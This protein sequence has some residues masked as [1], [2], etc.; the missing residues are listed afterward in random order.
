M[1]RTAVVTTEV[2]TFSELGPKARQKAI[3]NRTEEAGQYWEAG[4]LVK[5]WVEKLE[6]MG[7]EDVEINYSG[8][9]SQGDGASFTSSKF[10]LCH[11]LKQ[12]QLISKV[13]N[14]F[15]KFKEYDYFSAHH[16][17]VRSI[18]NNYSHYNTVRVEIEEYAAEHPQQELARE[19]LTEAV[20]DLCK[21]IYK[22]LETSYDHDTSEA[23]A[24]A[25]LEDNEE[26]NEFTEEGS[27]Y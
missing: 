24:I 3:D 22:E 17:T 10:D 7:F 13:P 15:R 18:C 19:L 4:W 23:Q 21:Q 11:M 16:C 1:S 25:Y 8:F 12:F 9:S 6:A 2:F 14:L 5:Q 20:R 26:E 27:E